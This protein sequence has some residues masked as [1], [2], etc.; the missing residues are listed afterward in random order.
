MTRLRLIGTCP[1]IGDVDVD[2]NEYP[3][4]VATISRWA[5][6]EAW[7]SVLIYSDHRQ[8]DPWSVAQLVIQATERLHPLIAVQPAYMHPFAVAKAV[9]TLSSLYDR[10]IHLNFVAGAFPRDLESLSMNLP[11]DQRYDRLAEYA[12]VVHLLLTQRQ[13]VNF[14]GNYYSI[15]E[16]QLDPPLKRN[17]LPSYTMSGSSPA[18]VRAARRAGAAT[19][20]YLGPPESFRSQTDTDKRESGVRLGIICAATT[21]EAWNVATAR[22]P[23]DPRGSMVQDYVT[24][25]SDST[26]VRRLGS[27]VR[28]DGSSSYWL[29]PFR[30]GYTSCPFLVGSVE[31]VAVSLA[32]YIMNGVTIFLIEQPATRAEAREI[33]LVFKRA[34]E[35]AMLS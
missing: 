32:T 24:E 9:Q 19:I 18:S 28:P 33:T 26:W 22:Y 17:L 14:S 1:M 8:A 10:R 3:H 25:T 20:S 27:L 30:N 34:S 2:V 12:E 35:L 6:E 31:E 7:E 5:E 23:A 15:A 4:R 16:L 13:P 21:T 29:S 11:H